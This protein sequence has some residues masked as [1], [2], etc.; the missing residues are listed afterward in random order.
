MTIPIMT[1]LEELFPY[2]YHSRSMQAALQ[3]LIRR[4]LYEERS[5]R[6]EDAAKEYNIS[7]VSLR[8]NMRAITEKVTTRIEL[9]DLHDRAMR[10]HHGEGLI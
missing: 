1:M 4:R 6:Q 3:Y 8:N 10:K 5:Y 7:T 2:K 9:A